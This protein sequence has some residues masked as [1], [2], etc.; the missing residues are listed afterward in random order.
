MFKSALQKIFALFW[1]N[2]I[3]F[4]IWKQSC[5]ALKVHV[6]MIILCKH[7]KAFSKILSIMMKASKIC[8]LMYRYIPLSQYILLI[9]AS[10]ISDL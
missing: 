10:H 9:S 5:F 6:E 2:S 1:S 7:S 4:N 3:D 8:F